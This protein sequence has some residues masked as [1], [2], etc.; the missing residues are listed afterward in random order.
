MDGALAK[1]A[2]AAEAEAEE[3]VEGDVERRW[4]K[5]EALWLDG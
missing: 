3:P 4:G 5:E 1:A 2:E